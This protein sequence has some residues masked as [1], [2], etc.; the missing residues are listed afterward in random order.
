MS[1]ESPLS[2]RA[3]TQLCAVIGN[4]VLHSLSPAMHNAAFH[5]AGLDYAYLAFTVSDLAGCL[6]G[7]RALEGFQGLSVTIPHKIAILSYLDEI[8]E[9]ALKIGSVNT[10]VKKDGKLLGTSTDGAGAF[11]AIEN[12][13]VSLKDASVLFAGTG[14]AARA[15][16]FALCTSGL[17]RKIM[18][19]GRS[20]EKV[21]ALTRDLETV[22]SSVEVL[23]GSFSENLL[24][25]AEESDLLINATPLGM[26]GA[27]EQENSFPGVGLRADQAV[28]DM[29]YRPENTVLVQEAKKQGC[30]IVPGLDMLLYQA[31][32][33][34]ELWTGACAPEEAMRQA[35][36]NALRSRE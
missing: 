13:G 35:L 11:R 18:I 8:E 12:A 15:V 22:S 29:V 24:A 25:W 32:I 1:A 27:A 30:K 10:V 5:A 16:A 34:F 14:G 20:A 2:I 23:G 4:P 33:Q 19:V 31:V 17:P 7:M 3:S 9:S 6:T 36:N 28:F 26:H 21:E